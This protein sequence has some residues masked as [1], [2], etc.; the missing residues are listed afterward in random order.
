MAAVGG[1]SYRPL[2]A[3][4][5]YPTSGASDDYALA[6]HLVDP[7]RN[8]TYGFTMEFGHPTNFYPTVPEFHAN[9]VDTASGF[10]EFCLAA[11]DLGLA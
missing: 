1:R 4:G 8:K 3:S 7:G 6:R 9:I 5:L 10:M 11:V 2:P